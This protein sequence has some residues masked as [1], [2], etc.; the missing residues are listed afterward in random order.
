[1][2]IEPWTMLSER[3][4]VKDRWIDLRA[5]HCRTPAGGEVEG[6]YVLHYPD[7]AHAVAVTPQGRFVLTRQWRE[8]SRTVS[9]EFAGGVVDPGETP[10]A[11]AAREL[12]EETGYRGARPVPV[13]SLWPNP[14]SQRNRLHTVLI[15]DA[16]RVAD[17]KTDANEVLEVEEVDAAELVEAIRSGA[18][19]HGL[20]LASALAVALHHPDLLS[21]AR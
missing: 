6:F 8:G 15:R 3:Q 2:T 4:V 13:S 10:E 1:M 5:E 14:A 12:S 7:W 21:L 20:H 17:P 11:A 19:D 16:V 9:L 18:L